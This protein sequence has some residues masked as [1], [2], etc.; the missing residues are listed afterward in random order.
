MIRGVDFEALAVWGEQQ[1]VW[2]V[3]SGKSGIS[4]AAIETPLAALASCRLTPHTLRSLGTPL[5]FSFIE[6]RDPWATSYERA[7]PFEARAKALKQILNINDIAASVQTLTL[8]SRKK[9]L[10]KSINGTLISEILHRVPHIRKFVLQSE[11]GS[12]DFSSIS[13][14]LA[15]TILALGRSPDIKTLEL[16]NIH[17]FPTTVVTAYSNLRC[18]RLWQIGFCVKCIFSLLS[19][20]INSTSQFDLKN[21]NPMGQ[22]SLDSLHINDGSVSSFR[23]SISGDISFATYFSRIKNLQLDN[24]LYNVFLDGTSCFWLQKLLQHSIFSTTAK[25]GFTFNLW[26]TTH[27]KAV[28][29]DPTELPNVPSA[30]PFDLGPFPALRHVKIQQRCWSG[31]NSTMLF[32]L[33]RLLSISS[34]T[35]GI[36][37]LEIKINWVDV[38]HGHARDLFPSSAGWSRLDETLA[39]DNFVSLKKVVLNLVLGMEV[40]LFGR[41][42][43]PQGLRAEADLIVS[44]LDALFLNLKLR[45]QCTVQILFDI[46]LIPSSFLKLP[47]S[48]HKHIKEKLAKLVCQGV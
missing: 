20:I 2:D 15:S 32:F 31:D 16:S 23:S 22:T 12:L 41:N 26:Y 4:S 37:T 6:L 40:A 9:H 10:E 38:E 30:V 48:P 47:K 36:E 3:A 24:V 33:N 14:D 7:Q 42:R 43:Y 27:N 39:C 28:P 45:N 25:V 18:L 19:A 17:L 11:E 35:S 21:V 13:E 29:V 34:S 1:Q 5:F 8:G 46:S 44:C